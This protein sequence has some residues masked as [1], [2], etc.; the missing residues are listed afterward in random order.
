MVRLVFTKSIIM[1]LKVSPIILEHLPTRIPHRHIPPT[2][3]PHRHIPPTPSLHYLPQ[4]IIQLIISS[5][6]KSNI[7]H[8]LHLK[9]QFICS[10]HTR[11]NEI[12]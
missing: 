9:L 12:S 7:L 1:Q 2:Q 4:R 11:M 8:S 5:R 6:S 3:L 10:Y